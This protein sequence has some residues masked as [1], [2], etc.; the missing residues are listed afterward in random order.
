MTVNDHLLQVQMK[1]KQYGG[2]MGGGGLQA[3]NVVF[4]S[5]HPVYSLFPSRLAV[6]VATQTCRPVSIW[7]GS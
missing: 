4:P 7:V 6:R 3:I 2:C 5:S 1:N